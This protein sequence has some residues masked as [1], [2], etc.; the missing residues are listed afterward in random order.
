MIDAIGP[1]QKLWEDDEAAVTIVPTFMVTGIAVIVGIVLTVWS[2]VFLRRRYGAAILMPLSVVLWLV[3]GGYAP[4]L[5]YGHPASLIASRMG[6]PLRLWRKPLPG[7]VRRVLSRIWL[8]ILT[9]FVACFVLSV[10]L[11]ILGWPLPAFLDSETVLNAVTQFAFPYLFLIF[12]SIV[13]SFPHD[14]E[15]QMAVSSITLGG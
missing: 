4:P 14:V 8:G 11:I 6:N 3:G 1:A 2:A 10:A 5:F 12:V 9:L 7:S 13:S 15:I